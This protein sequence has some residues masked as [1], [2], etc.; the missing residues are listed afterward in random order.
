MWKEC[1]M[2]DYNEIK[3]AYDECRRQSLKKNKELK[4]VSEELEELE[5]VKMRSEKEYQ[6]NYSAEEK[7]AQ[8]FYKQKVITPIENKITELETKLQ[9]LQNDHKAELQEAT[10]ENMLKNCATEQEILNDLKNSAS[11][12]SK[13]LQSILSVRFYKELT[14][15]LED[16][17]IKLKQS[18]LDKVIKYF[19]KC[20]KQLEK[21]N[22]END[23]IG[24]FLQSLENTLEEADVQQINTNRKALVVFSLVLIVLS[25]FAYRYLF[26]LYLIF[27]LIMFGYNLYRSYTLYKIM[28][29]HKAVQDNISVIDNLLREKILAEVESQKEKI[30]SFYEK[31]IKDTEDKILISKQK[32]IDASATADASF[33]FD[34]S[35]LKRLYEQ[36]KI[37]HQTRESELYEKQYTIKDEIDQIFTRQK[38]LKEQLDKLVGDYKNIYLNFQRIGTSFLFDPTFLFDIDEDKSRPVFF[39]HPQGSCLF[40]YHDRA[41]AIGFIKLIVTQLRSRLAPSSQRVIYYDTQNMGQDCIFFS[42]VLEN[43]NDP[44]SSLF[45]IFREDS[46]LKDYITNMQEEMR[47][48]QKDLRGDGNISIYNK[49]M[50]EIE[51]LTLPYLFSFIMDPSQELLNSS[52]STI[53]RVS[54]TYGI[55][56]HVFMEINSFTEMGKN[57]VRSLDTFNEVYLLQNGNFNTRA[58]DYVISDIL[59]IG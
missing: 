26:P 22:D 44:A 14:S 6:Q 58:K 17:V 37:R 19:N 53:T 33:S 1:N 55:F 8:Q 28:I 42:P 47:S 20:D 15:Q 27:L 51:S 4:R 2:A 41:D 52:I 34:G 5:A 48:R 38:E 21:M 45:K 46:E 16:N 25:F 49:H 10:E 40:L 57:V 23:T 12:V 3:K 54:G 7:E 39:K 29:V 13:R 56:V 31:E 35:D 18:D 59:G 24:N 11:L 36:T 9:D 32:L 30:N 50:L 43:K